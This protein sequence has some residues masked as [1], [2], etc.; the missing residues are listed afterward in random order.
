MIGGWEVL[1]GKWTGDGSCAINHKAQTATSS[2]EHR[3]DDDDDHAAP[4]QHGAQR[5]PPSRVK[6]DN[7]TG[8][9]T[10]WRQ[11]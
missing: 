6:G 11:R 9:S 4:N 3:Y 1:L 5:V 8:I 2:A 7:N 10:G